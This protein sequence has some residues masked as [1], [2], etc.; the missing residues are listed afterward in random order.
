MAGA[1]RRMAS[2]LGLVEDDDLIEDGD[3]PDDEDPFLDD[4]TFERGTGQ[5]LR[6][7]HSEAS[8]RRPVEPAAPGSFGARSPRGTSLHTVGSSALAERP[9][10]RERARPVTS[11][12]VSRIT[13][14]HPRAYN[15]ARLIGEEFRSGVPVILNLTELDDADAKRI[16]DF[17]AGLAFGLHGTIERVTSKVFLLSPE[18]VDV[19]EQ[20]RVQVA[21]SGFFNQS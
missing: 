18:C 12:V 1:L 5:P 6:A 15:E 16:I 2:Y 20:A 13:T 4:E 19:G 9:L 14:L 17:A 11:H 7:V 8:F 3:F 21:G 10:P